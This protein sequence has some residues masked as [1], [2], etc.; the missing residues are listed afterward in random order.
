[1]KVKYTR[2]GLGGV[3]DEEV[4]KRIYFMQTSPFSISKRWP[5]S[6]TSASVVSSTACLSTSCRNCLRGGASQPRRPLR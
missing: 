3:A 2:K 5:P 4:S 1:M 6:L